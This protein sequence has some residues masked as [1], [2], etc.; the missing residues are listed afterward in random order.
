M[1]PG[2]VPR[3][4]SSIPFVSPKEDRVIPDKFEYAAPSSLPE[5]FDL[6]QRRDGEAKVLAG[7]QSL[8]PLMKFRLAAPALLVDL[9]KVPHLEV[10]QERNG[11]LVIGAMVR[12]ARLDAS[13]L[14]RTRY[15]G[16]HDATGVVADPLVR[17]FATLGGNLAHADPAND[18]PAMM[19]ALRAQ[20]VAAGPSGQR[21]L[22]IDDFLVDTLENALASDEVLTEIHV[23]Q[24]APR[25]GSAYIK[26]ERK[27]GDYAIAAVGAQLALD[28]DTCTQA[29][30][31]LTNVGP[32][33]IRASAAEAF[34]VGTPVTEE[35]IREAARLA[36]EAADP[37]SDLRGPAEYKRAMV[38]TLTARALRQA[39]QRA[40]GGDVR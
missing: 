34:L 18:H 33:A 37:T 22:S 30:I 12:E 1:P 15:P 17:N 16:I 25:S 3:V 14:I 19:V 7:G 27:V 39:Y 32:K 6:L 10:L 5:V 26:L 28:G 29:G 2:A 40:T 36:S 20:V 13:N 11:S 38:R 31:G 21:T 9:R 35:T 4:S 24:P 8:I 23:P